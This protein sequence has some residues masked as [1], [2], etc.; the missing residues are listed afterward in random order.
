MFVIVTKPCFSFLAA[1][2][3]ISSRTILL[4]TYNS[5]TVKGCVYHRKY[6]NKIVSI[7]TYPVQKEQT[8][9]GN[10]TVI[11]MHNYK[12]ACEK[13]NVMFQKLTINHTQ[14]NISLPTV[15]E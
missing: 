6:A 1:I 10:Y 13:E 15:F 4:I 8:E 14:T 2:P 12:L 3:S 9:D 5:A 11:Y 7:L